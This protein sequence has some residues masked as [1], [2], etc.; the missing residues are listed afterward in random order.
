MNEIQT[1]HGEDAMIRSM[2]TRMSEYL[3]DA[4]HV[5]EV[6]AENTLLKEKVTDLE[7]KLM[8]AE[9]GKKTWQDNAEQDRKEAARLQTEVYRLAHLLDTIRGI[10]VNNQTSLVA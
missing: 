3:R 10:V 7:W 1:V 8:L 4:V 5:S 6:R 9:E 2:M